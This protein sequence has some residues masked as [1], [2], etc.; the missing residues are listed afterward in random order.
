ML[1]AFTLH[2]KL[3]PFGTDRTTGWYD[4]YQ[5]AALILVST[6]QYLKNYT[7]FSKCWSLDGSSIYFLTRFCPFSTTMP[8]CPA[9]AGRP[10]RV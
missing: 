1:F 4:T 6:F 7:Y 9:V 5:T 2:L 8:R 3:P 10:L